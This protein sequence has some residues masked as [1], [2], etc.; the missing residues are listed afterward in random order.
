MLLRS[1]E[2][3]IGNMGERVGEFLASASLGLAL[4]KVI[5]QQLLEYVGKPL[6]NKILMVYIYSPNHI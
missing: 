3:I 1:Q 5:A 4:L 6:S 2:C